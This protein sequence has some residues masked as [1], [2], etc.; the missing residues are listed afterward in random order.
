MSEQEQ[1]ANSSLIRILQTNNAIAFASYQG[2]FGECFGESI[3][4]YPPHFLDYS[5]GHRFT[6]QMEYA[7]QSGLLSQKKN[8]SNSYNHG[9][10]L[11]NYIIFNLAL[12][13][14]LSI[15]LVILSNNSGQVHERFSLSA[16]ETIFDTTWRYD[17]SS[18]MLDIC[19]LLCYLLWI[20]YCVNGLIL[21]RY[22][23]I[24]IQVLAEKLTGYNRGETLFHVQEA[25]TLL[26]G[27]FSWKKWFSEAFRLTSM[28]DVYKLHSVF[29]LLPLISIFVIK[30]H[31]SPSSIPNGI[32]TGFAITLVILLFA[33]FIR[34]Q[35]LQFRIFIHKFRIFMSKSIN[36]RGPIE[37]IIFK[38]LSPAKQLLDIISPQDDFFI[39]SFLN[40]SSSDNGTHNSNFLFIHEKHEFISTTCV[41]IFILVLY[42]FLGGGML[43]ITLRIEQTALLYVDPWLLFIPIYIAVGMVMTYNLIS[44]IKLSF[45]YAY[46][47]Q[48][49]YIKSA[50]IMFIF[51]IF[52][53]IQSI[54]IAYISVGYALKTQEVWLID[55]MSI[56]LPLCIFE[57]VFSLVGVTVLFAAVVRMISWMWGQA[58]FVSK[59]SESED[60]EV[61]V[62]LI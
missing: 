32:Q 26:L 7:S 27:K 29:W 52:L 2:G 31:L 60:V 50:L 59:R 54:C 6:R 36:R 13:V 28:M 55:W 5:N 17:L 19:L 8:L 14:P 15:I 61:S 42:L 1:E 46:Q 3:N 41:H 12:S 56:F 30:N 37:K 34:G 38:F 40:V 44:H 57:I 16:F 47:N 53:L 11:Y 10:K 21:F 49:L 45:S 58:K 43:S 18:I 48:R 33:S 9:T 24:V 4:V 23:S 39:S 25:Q 20:D 51:F 22:I 62:E 35:Y